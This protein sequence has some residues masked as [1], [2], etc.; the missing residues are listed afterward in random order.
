MT[1]WFM[2]SGHVLIAIVLLWL[3]GN[4]LRLPILAVPPVLAQIQADLGMSGTEVG[5]LSGLP[6]TLFALAAL[7]G[8][9]LIARIG[10]TS[11]L[12][13]GLAI[14]ALGSG[15]RF[16]VPNVA[17]LYAATVVMSAGIAVMQPALPAVVR[18]WLPDRIGFATAVYTNGLIV[19]EILPVAAMTT[20]V[21]PLAAGD[22]RMALAFWAVPLFLIVVMIVALAPRQGTARAQAG[23]QVHWWPDWRNPL[24]WRFGLMIGGVNSAYFGS[25]AFLPGYL[26]NAGRGDLIAAALTALNLGQLPASLILLAVA[27]RFQGRSWPLI[28]AG[29][30]SIASIAGI[31]LTASVWTVVFAGVLG[32]C[33]AA[34]LV[35]ALTLPPL[36][37][38]PAQIA[39][40]SAAM[41]AMGYTEALTMSVAGGALWDLTGHVAAAFVPLALGLLPLVLLPGTIQFT[42][43]TGP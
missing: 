34:V 37:M 36:L 3:A 15:L 27:R 4:A 16:Y 33:A 31:A 20:L 19:G 23:G 38:P 41:F 9:L 28:A 24:V 14:A 22:W 1:E 5:I 12:V 10:A 13:A 2:Q 32:F 43:R 6:V 8:S 40:T 17:W 30:G 25:N 39:P 26:T 35:L 7:P 29:L 21:M 42:R 11:A 18:Q